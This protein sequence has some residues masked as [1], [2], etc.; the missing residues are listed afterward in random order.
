MLLSRDV[1]RPSPRAIGQLVATRLDDGFPLVGLVYVGTGPTERFRERELS[2]E[3]ARP[4]R[5]QTSVRTRLGVI[6]TDPNDEVGASVP[7]SRSEVGR[8][9]GATTGAHG[10]AGFQNSSA[11]MQKVTIA[12]PLRTAGD[13]RVLRRHLAPPAAGTGAIAT[14]RTGAR[15]ST[16]IA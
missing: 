8:D 2:I 16:T 15:W 11:S 4:I 9:A 14:P 10:A 13:Q 1:P 5:Q 7:I 12:S 6:L 3:H